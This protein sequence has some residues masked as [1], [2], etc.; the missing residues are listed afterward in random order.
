MKQGILFLYI[1]SLLIVGNYVFS[2]EASVSTDSAISSDS[3]PSGTFDV[4]GTSTMAADAANS[5]TTTSS[6]TSSDS[7]KIIVTERVPG[8]D[9]TCM[10]DGKATNESECLSNISKRTYECTVPQ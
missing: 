8:G 4:N 7:M 1:G 3:I 10:I 2:A 6:S 5:T 9:C